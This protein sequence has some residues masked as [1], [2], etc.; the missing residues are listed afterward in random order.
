MK[1]I[2][3]GLPKPI[4]WLL[5]L[6]PI[7]LTIAGI[8]IIYSLT[9]YNNKIGLFYSQ[10]IYAAIGIILMS[11]FTFIDY[12]N[13]QG[14]AWYLYFAG[15]ILLIL[16]LFFGKTVLGASR[17]LDLKIF[18]LQPA[19]FFKLCLII[20]LA[21]FFSD[22]IDK[23]NFKNI[24][25]GIILL[26]IPGILVLRQPDL[27]TLM[28]LCFIT[29][30]IILSAK[31]SRIQLLTLGVIILIVLPGTWFLLKDY[32]RQ[33]LST[34]LNPNA[35]PY[36]S[37]YNVL[38]STITVGSGGLLGRGLGHGPQS[39][40]NFLPIVY[41]D[42]IFAGLAEASGFVGS[43]ILIVL[44]MFLIARILSI[45]RISKDYFGTLIAIGIAAMLIFQVFVNIGMNIGILPVTG[46]PLPFVSSGGTS[47]IVNFIC[48]GILQS[49][50]LRHKKIT[51]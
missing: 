7:I 43:V 51:F 22:R 19:E 40:L 14:V 45:A 23:I 3:F 12:R 41:T 33:R 17:W 8:V 38:Q 28:V 11:I 50:Y 13:F 31:I 2:N 21:K 39:Q 32:Q 9:Y 16:V 29:L 25:F 24:L 5:Y 27:G 10:I 20:M 35:D 48:V 30:M 4:D 18:Q 47:L 37:G 36:G 42:F 15:L 44:F 1:K 49:I 6:I 46:I 26:I 34:F